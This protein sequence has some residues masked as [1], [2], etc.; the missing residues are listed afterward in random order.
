MSTAM[1]STQN[2]DLHPSGPGLGEELQLQLQP[3]LVPEHQDRGSVR[4]LFS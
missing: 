2:S 3:P 4:I 1:S